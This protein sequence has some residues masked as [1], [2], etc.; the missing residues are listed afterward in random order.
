ML[1]TEGYQVYSE[2]QQELQQEL[3]QSCKEYLAMFSMCPW[4]DIELVGA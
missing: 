1:C 2:V 3:Q 4:V